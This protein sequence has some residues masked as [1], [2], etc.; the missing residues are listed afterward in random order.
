MLDDAAAQP[1]QPGRLRRGADRRGVDHE[2]VVQVGDVAPS[3]AA[4]VLR[5][6][7]DRE[8]LEVIGQEAPDE[9][10][11]EAV[12]EQ[13]ARGLERPRRDD[14]RMPGPHLPD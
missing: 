11:T 6:D 8:R 14:H 4:G 5:E 1:G 13:E 3:L 9:V 10:A 12:A 2:V 7:A